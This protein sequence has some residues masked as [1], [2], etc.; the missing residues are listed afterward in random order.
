MKL[1]PLWLVAVLAL[2]LALA[3]PARADPQTIPQ[4]QSAAGLAALT[5]GQ[6]QYIYRSDL[7]VPFQWSGSNCAVSDAWHV[8]PNAGTG[9]WIAVTISASGLAAS[10][11]SALSAVSSAPVALTY[12]ATVTPNFALGN[13]FTVTLTGNVTFANPTNQTAGQSGCLAITQ[14]GSGSRTASWGTNWNWPAGVTP[15][16]TTTAA[17]TDDVCFWVSVSGTIHAN[18]ASN[19]L[20]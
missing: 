18:I 14:D 17:A 4:A 12:A 5:A 6:Y 19:L 7:G 1:K 16:L 13:F 3:S 10:A 8:S 20:P 11:P 2:V 15:V 9:C